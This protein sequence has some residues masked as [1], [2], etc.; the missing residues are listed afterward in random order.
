[1]TVDK[2]KRYI[3]VDDGLG[4]A[5][6]QEQL[7]G[8]WVTYDNYEAGQKKLSPEVRSLLSRCK[9]LLLASDNPDHTGH[10]NTIADIQKLLEADQ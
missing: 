5:E 10:A 8:D 3:F 4:Y 2:V 7:D 6:M 1:M 9:M